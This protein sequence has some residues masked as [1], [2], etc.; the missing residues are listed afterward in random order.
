MRSL[1]RFGLVAVLGCAIGVAGAS[2]VGA[3]G[4]GS[5]V[6]SRQV[7]DGAQLMIANSNGTGERSVPLPWELEYFA[8]G[9]WSPDRHRILVS[10]FLR[11]DGNG[12]L[13][14]FRPGV[15]DTD[16]SRFRLLDPPGFGF[17]LNC[18]NWSPDGTRILCA[19]GDD[20]TGIWSLRVK[21]GTGQHHITHGEKDL[22]VGYAPNGSQMAFIR[23]ETLQ[24][25]GSD[26]G[27]RSAL[28]VV[29]PDGTGLR[30]LTDYGVVMGHEVAS[31]AWSADG[32]TL[33]TSTPDGRLITVDVRSHAICRI[34][35]E[36]GIN[37][38]F[39]FAPS[40]APGGNRITFSLSTNG[41]PDIYTA[42]TD[43]KDVKKVTDTPDNEIFPDWR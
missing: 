8:R 20:R 30:Q 17:D 23:T 16:G 35:L 25:G 34:D 22:P 14:P 11:F 7:A 2:Q 27:E 33:L 6:F 3:T 37:E 43:G 31:G 9:V 36:V 4:S 13:L 21:D 38:Y 10:A 39:A 29:K 18:T 1:C 41:G 19:A 24:A 42:R 5:I 15:V 26:D 12:E 28:F 32:R 40:Y